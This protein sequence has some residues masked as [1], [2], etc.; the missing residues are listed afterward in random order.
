[1]KRV[2]LTLGLA[3]AVVLIGRAA[4]ATESVGHV[5]AAESE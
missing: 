3:A 2:T 5:A 4:Q 1:M